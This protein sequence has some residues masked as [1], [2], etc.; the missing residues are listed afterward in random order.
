M[1]R[2]KIVEKGELET[3]EDNCL[4]FVPCSFSSLLEKAKGTILQ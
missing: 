3:A 1:L 2:N 4:E